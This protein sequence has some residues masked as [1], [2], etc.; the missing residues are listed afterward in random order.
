MLANATNWTKRTLDVSGNYDSF[1][2]DNRV[3]GV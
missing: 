2:N 1:G 3:C